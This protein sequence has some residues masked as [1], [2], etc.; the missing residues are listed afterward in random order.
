MEVLESLRIKTGP[1]TFSDPIPISSEAKHVKIKTSS[2]SMNDSFYTYDL[3]DVVGIIDVE[4]GGSI[5]DRLD[6]FDLKLTDLYYV[7]IKINSFTSSF[8]NPVV[9]ISGSSEDFNIS[10]TWST[11]KTPV[12][13]TLDG[14]T[15]DPS[16][17][18]HSVVVAI[19]DITSKTFR[20]AA[21][22]AGA[23][24]KEPTTATSAL[25]IEWLNGVYYGAAAA[26]T[27]ID[28][29]F[30]KSLQ[31]KLQKSKSLSVSNMRATGGKYFWYACP[32][33]LGTPTFKIGGFTSALD[34]VAENFSFTN[35]SGYT[36]T[37]NVWRTQNEDPGTLGFTAE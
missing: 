36:E 4:H 37:Y 11:S 18:S 20:L 27:Q 8:T 1:N 10:F 9:E 5:A 29:N 25:T 14:E 2:D 16:A 22:D 31:R 15:L 13:L 12:T 32:A 7:P 28:N 34:L 30:I 3:Q 19:Q 24:S 35:G 17:T 33:R 6:A 26:P 21:T 23:Y